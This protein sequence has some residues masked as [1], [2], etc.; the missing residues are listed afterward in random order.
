MLRD[1][2]RL[3]TL[4][5]RAA[6]AAAFLGLLLSALPMP[7][8]SAAPRLQ[9]EEATIAQIQTA[10]LH[11]RITTEQVVRG[12]L[13]RIRAYNGVCVRQPDGVLG[14]IET[15]ANAGQ[16]NALSTL[17]LRPASR[18]ALG[19]DERKA[20][21]MTDDVDNDPRMPDALETAVAQD[22]EFRLTGKLVGPLQGVM[23]ALKD[24]YDTFDMRSTSGADAFYAND[25]PP[26]DATFVQRLRQ[27]GAIILAKANLAE[28][29]SGLPRSS[30][31]GVFCNPYDTTRT[32]NTSSAGSG[33]AVAA[34]LVTC[35]IGE[36]TGSSIRA[37]ASS[38]NTVGLA[39]TQELV[40][41][42][43][44]MQMG[45]N[46]RVG[47]IC[48][49]VEDTARVLDA[50]AGYD[51]ADPLTVFS[52]G[53]KPTQPY[54]SFVQGKDLKGLRIGV[55]R[56]YMSRKLF[57]VADIAA[58]DIVSRGVDELRKLG[59][60]MVDPGD[61]GELFTAC[62]RE[63]VPRYSNKLFTQRHPELFPVDGSG[64]PRGDHIKTLVDM[65]MDPAL[66]PDDVNLR[67]LDRGRAVGE[68]RFE[69]NL[70]LRQRGDSNIRSNTDLVNKANYYV[71]PNF[72]SQKQSREN[73]DKPMEL[74]SAS[75]LQGRFAVQTMILQCMAQLQLDA[76]VYPTDN[77][78]PQKIG[79]P[80]PPAING[81]GSNTVW[82][83][84]GTQGFPAITVPA[85][86][87]TEVYDYV[88]D[89]DAAL[90]PAE[91]T[92]NNGRREAV[93]LVGPVPARLPVGMDIVARPFDEPVLL[94]IAAAY[95]RATRHR[96]APEGFGPVPALH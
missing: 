38:N 63:Y 44:M 54:Q 45:L 32:P 15:I 92:N 6:C 48:R 67:T 3:L 27:A 1:C 53:R 41:R 8:Q 87:T 77:V 9:L 43:G 89:A 4:R 7:S 73:A 37:P 88:R 72:S 57:T 56:E 2:A 55:V 83:F 42:K 84:L 66:V 17:N 34:N 47:P 52:I 58:I 64:A 28:Y 78:P 31:G 74:D 49:T 86:F 65:T 21:T 23:I 46:T 5:Y 36:E 11:K 26:A 61:A 33:S 13:D 85:G 29:A 19:F 69:L 81:R 95:E 10:I 79:A 22:R 16:V 60:T 20:R 40:S 70:Y 24:Q 59:A 14:R 94:R 68:G 91:T 90:P 51:P 93:K 75:R 25:R 30:F 71:D 50:Y 18:T 39:P 12:Y 80:D 62:L 76:L 35:A 96:V 82:S